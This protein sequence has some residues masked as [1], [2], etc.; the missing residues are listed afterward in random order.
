[1]AIE[2]L[3]LVNKPDLA[4]T[5]EEQLRPQGRVLTLQGAKSMASGYNRLIKE[6]TADVLCLIHQDA[7]LHFDASRIVPQYFAA[8]A[9]SRRSKA[10]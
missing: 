9:T 4:K 3:M 5:A 7:E 1:M 6:A 8:R 2:F 10:P